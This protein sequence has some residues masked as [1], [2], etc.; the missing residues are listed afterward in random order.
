MKI[1][2]SDIRY[3]CP[4]CDTL[5]ELDN[6]A[7]ECNWFGDDDYSSGVIYEDDDDD[8]Y[9][10]DDEPIS[11]CCNCGMDTS[12]GVTFCDQPDSPAWL[13]WYCP[14]CG[15]A[16]FGDIESIE[17]EIEYGSGY[18]V[19]TGVYDASGTIN[20]AAFVFHADEVDDT[21]DLTIGDYRARN[22]AHNIEPTEEN[23]R[24]IIASHALIAF[25]LAQKESN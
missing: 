16:R 2:S 10:E 3:I 8:Y 14:D 12:I 20:G 6:L 17:L 13:R 23:V 7:H 19:S 11:Q 25:G 21:W 15:R 4:V 5:H 24:H 1:K 9:D 22:L 18:G